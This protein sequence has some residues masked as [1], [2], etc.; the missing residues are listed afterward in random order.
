MA[1]DLH[2]AAIVAATSSGSTARLVARFRPTCPVLGLTPN[3]ETQR[4]LSLSWGVIPALV[5]PFSDTDQIFELA[6]L[7]ALEHDVAQTGDSLIVTAG[8]PVGK[9]GTTNVVKVLKIE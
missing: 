5:A 2:A 8:V 6:K 3:P 9:P 1:Q 4:Q 7:W